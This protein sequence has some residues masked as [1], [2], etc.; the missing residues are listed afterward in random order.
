MR[1][2]NKLPVD[3]KTEGTSSPTTTT[4]SPAAASMERLM[5]LG[6]SLDTFAD[7]SFANMDDS[8]SLKDNDGRFAPSMG[9]SL[10]EEEPFQL[11]PPSRQKSREDIMDNLLDASNHRFQSG[12]DSPSQTTSSQRAALL[13]PKRRSSNSHLSSTMSSHITSS[14]N[15]S[16]TMESIFEE[17]EVDVDV[18]LRSSQ[19]SG[20]KTDSFKGKF[21]NLLETTLE[22]EEGSDRD[23]NPA[24][25]DDEPQV[26]EVTEP[27]ASDPPA[28]APAP[29]STLERSNDALGLWGNASVHLEELDGRCPVGGVL[30]TNKGLQEVGS[31]VTLGSEW[32]FDSCFSMNGLGDSLRVDTSLPPP[33]PGAMNGLRFQPNYGSISPLLPPTR[34]TSTGTTS[35]PQE[36]SV[37]GPSMPM[38]RRSRFLPDSAHQAAAFASL[39]ASSSLDSKNNSNHSATSLGASGSHPSASAASTNNTNHCLKPP[40]RQLSSGL[41]GATLA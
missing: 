17:I 35:K 24:E 25:E 15:S 7:A 41:T 16:M 14:F 29:A 12:L 4:T 39:Q 3:A 32:G 9:S 31:S 10:P 40:Q 26:E 19:S 27:L 1:S 36:C 11:V 34:A 8:F 38:R 33:P 22:N 23:S 2:A 6:A 13:P 30:E 20:R 28:S 37:Q 21:R 5:E 18:D